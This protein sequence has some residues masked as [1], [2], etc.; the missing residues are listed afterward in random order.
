MVISVYPVGDNT[1]IN[2]IQSCLFRTPC[3]LIG[4]CIGSEVKES[5]RSCLIYLIPIILYI[6]L[7]TFD[8]FS[9]VYK[10]WIWALLIAVLFAQLFS[11]MSR[12]RLY[13]VITLLNIGKYT[14]ELYIG[15]DISKNILI[16]FMGL[17][18]SYWLLSICGSI[19]FAFLYNVVFLKIFS[20]GLKWS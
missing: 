9:A 19:V 15:L 16:Q 10:G 11:Y 17:G 18:T 6:I 7:Q 20:K 3:Y 8:S 12:S 1:I 5:K 14:L 13:N 4:L 2:T